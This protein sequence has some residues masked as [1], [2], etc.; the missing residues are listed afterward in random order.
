MFVYCRQLLNAWEGCLHWDVQKLFLQFLPPMRR[1]YLTLL[2]RTG[3]LKDWRRFS[4]DGSK[5]GAYAEVCYY[6]LLELYSEGFVF[7]SAQTGL[8]RDLRVPGQI[9]NMVPY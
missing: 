3:A 9:K 7:S 8:L 1:N 2:E 6:L 4:K 5:L